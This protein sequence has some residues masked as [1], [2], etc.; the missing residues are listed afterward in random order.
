MVRNFSAQLW[1]SEWPA[2]NSLDN[3][4]GKIP[5]VI[6]IEIRSYITHGRKRHFALFPLFDLPIGCNSVYK[7]STEVYRVIVSFVKFGAAKAIFY[8]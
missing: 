8:L 1:R 2:K 6:N 7:M 3:I 4:K 5:Q